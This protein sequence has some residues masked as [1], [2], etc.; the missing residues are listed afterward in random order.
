METAKLI[1]IT[2]LITELQ[3][4][5]IALWLRFKAEKTTRL[6][7]FVMILM[8]AYY[9]ALLL[10]YVYGFSN[11]AWLQLLLKDTPI[12]TALMIFNFLKRRES[13]SVKTIN[14]ISLLIFIFLTG[15]S[16]VTYYRV[17]RFEHFQKLMSHGMLQHA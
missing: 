7:S 1:L 4:T 9:T 6:L 16:F 15:L 3:A 10:H 8:A 11:L 12:L 5:G 17:V 2:G 13:R 14:I